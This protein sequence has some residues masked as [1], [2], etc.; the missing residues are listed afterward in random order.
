MQ[1]GNLN[2][3][4]SKSRISIR[5]DANTNPKL[6]WRFKA[7]Q[8]QISVKLGEPVLAFYEAKNLAKTDIT[9]TALFNV[10][11]LKAGQYFSKIDCF[12]FNKQTLMAGQRMDMP[13]QFF[14]DP[15]IHNDPNTK[16]VTTIT[17]SYTF[18]PASSDDKPNES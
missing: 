16:D 10:T 2:L 13:V 8:D 11:P 15:E 4:V 12:C 6:P 18:Y 5:F 3:R 1:V 9:G 17:L 14:V 7:T